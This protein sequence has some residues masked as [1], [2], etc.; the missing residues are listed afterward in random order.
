MSDRRPTRGPNINARE[1]VGLHV[2]FDRQREG[3]ELVRRIESGDFSAETM[4]RLAE[5]LG[6]QAPKPNG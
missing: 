3:D 6:Q 1:R 4:E 2:A 5:L